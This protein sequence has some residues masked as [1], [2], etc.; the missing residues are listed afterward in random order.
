MESVTVTR[1][2][3][4]SPEAIEAAMDD[5]AGFVR[6]AGFDDVG[7]LREGWRADVVGLSTDNARSTPIHDPYSHLAFAAHGD[8][9]T[10]TMVD[11]EVL[12]RDGEHV[13][14]DAEGVRERARKF[15]ARL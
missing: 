14:M 7:K 11:G 5:W 12:Y 4:A 1:E 10:L 6:A 15:A 2:I 8:D 13:R 3:A 9:V